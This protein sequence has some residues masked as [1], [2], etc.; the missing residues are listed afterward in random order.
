[1]GLAESQ[2][3]GRD[4]AWAGSP[5]SYR[6]AEAGGRF[7]FPEIWVTPYSPHQEVEKTGIGVQT[8]VQIPVFDLH[9]RCDLEQVVN[10]S[11]PRCPH[12]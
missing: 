1:M 9:K 6:L 4:T 3:Q 5:I 7:S 2:T 8:W 11:E 10:Y 12:L